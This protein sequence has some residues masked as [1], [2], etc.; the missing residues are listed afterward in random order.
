MDK[1][2]NFLEK[3]N[4]NLCWVGSEKPPKNYIRCD[5]KINIFN[6]KNAILG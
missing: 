1:I 3:D 5:N 2:V 6:K 4:H